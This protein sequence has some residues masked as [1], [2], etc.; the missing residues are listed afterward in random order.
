MKKL[1]LVFAALGLMMQ[2]TSCT[3]NQEHED[4]EF[5]ENADVDKIESED[6][7]SLQDDS[8]I[9]SSGTQAQSDNLTLD[10]SLEE[11]LGTSSSDNQSSV[12][13]NNTGSDLSLEEQI[14]NSQNVAAAPTLDET[15]LSLDDTSTQQSTN[16]NVA[17]LSLDDPASTTTFESTPT[18]Q[19]ADTSTLSELNLSGTETQQQETSSFVEDTPAPKVAASGS[20]KK[21]SEQKPYAHGTGFVNTIYIVRPKE[22]LKDISQTIYGSDK[23]KELK[24]INSFLKARSPRA[25]DKVAYVS[26]HRP[27]DSSRMIS[28]YEDTGMVPETYVAKKGDNLKKVSKKLLGYDRAWQEV[29]TTNSIDTKGRLAEG[30]TFRYWKSSASIT[31]VANNN[32]NVI[33]SPN[34]L[35]QAPPTV[36]QNDFNSPPPDMAPPTPPIGD[37]P[38]PPPGSELP[39]PPADPAMDAMAM[40]QEMPPPPADPAMDASVPPPPPPEVPVADEAQA[41]AESAPLLND[42]MMVMLGVG[43]VLCGALAYVLI[44]RKRKA[45]ADAMRETNI[46]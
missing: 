27:N 6:S 36:A 33:T 34:E 8:V 2:I 22:T 18:E 23:T 7:L 1:L 3:A 20:L 35:P 16:S 12:A 4:A 11:A 29:W 15:S 43:I 28:F 5:V 42:D 37:M 26:P 19:L 25:G 30:E 44:R 38:P 21:I 41:S 17:E 13:Q 39:P 31:P 45:E 24:D 10:N 32:A 14:D 9:E 40:N 46:G